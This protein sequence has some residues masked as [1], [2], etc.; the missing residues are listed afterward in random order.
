MGLVSP[1]AVQWVILREV[2]VREA[3][4]HLAEWSYRLL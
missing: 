1:Q 2:P 4:L 3:A